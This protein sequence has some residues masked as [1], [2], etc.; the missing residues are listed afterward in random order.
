MQIRYFSFTTIGV[1]QRTTAENQQMIG[2]VRV[3][4]RMEDGT[5]IDIG[6]DDDEELRN[7]FDSTN[8][9]DDF[10]DTEDEDNE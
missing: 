1:A 5:V 4:R 6:D 9:C 8:P 2:L 7:L 10:I 3:T